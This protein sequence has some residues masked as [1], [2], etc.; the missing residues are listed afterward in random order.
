M[1]EQQLTTIS[2]GLDL[3]LTSTGVAI[4]RHYTDGTIWETYSVKSK[5]ESA[6]WDDRLRRI[7]SIVGD[8][9][10]ILYGLDYD[11]AT[12]EGF[13][14]IVV[15]E[16]PSYGSKN[17]G[18]GHERAGLWWQVYR[19]VW[20]T[21]TKNIIVVPPTVRAKYATGRG[22][23]GKDEVMLA[24]AK[25]YPEAAIGDNNVADAVILADI[26]L[27]QMRVESCQLPVTH[28]AALKT[29]TA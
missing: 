5:R 20:V 15:I 3:S 29:L 26:G 25:R 6:L 2:V 28:T 23:A 16:G 8:I 4:A 27:R 11:V 1:T 13:T 7:G 24:T 9:S 10:R 22:N 14:R 19:E 21:Y 18:S 17:S 12:A